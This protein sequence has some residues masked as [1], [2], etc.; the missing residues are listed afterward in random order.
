SRRD[1]NLGVKQVFF[2]RLAARALWPQTELWQ[3]CFGTLKRDTAGIP[4][5]WRH[6]ETT[7]RLRGRSYFST[8]KLLTTEKT[9]DTPLARMF[10]RSLSPWVDTTPS[11]VTLPFSTM[12]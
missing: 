11:R 2:G 8:R 12:M 1:L 4:V 3:L 5:A 7:E 10:A 6:G 9:P